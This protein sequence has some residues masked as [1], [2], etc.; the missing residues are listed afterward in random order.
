MLFKLHRVWQRRT[1]EDLKD[2][3]FVLCLWISLFL[4]CQ[5][6]EG[7]TLRL[8]K[9]TVRYDET[10]LGGAG[11]P[12]VEDLEVVDNADENLNGLL[13][14][15]TCIVRYILNG[16][17]LSHMLLYCW[18]AILCLDI[19]Q[20]CGNTIWQGIV[21]R[22]YSICTAI[23]ELEAF[24]VGLTLNLMFWVSFLYLGSIQRLKESA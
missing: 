9:V 14:F 1:L 11:I 5:I 16:L 23:Y 24:E 4:S 3:Y 7:S 6:R 2:L 17:D 8:R 12:V 15:I 21:G 13:L 19:V 18:P 22:L 10:N 20:H